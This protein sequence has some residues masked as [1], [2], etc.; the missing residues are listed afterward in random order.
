[1]RN[2][3]YSLQ[4]FSN[5]R[6]FL[7][8]F[9]LSTTI[10]VAQ[11]QTDS[12]KVVSPEQKKEIQEIIKSLQKVLDSIQK[13][14]DAIRKRIV[15]ER[16]YI[17]KWNVNGRLTFLFNQTAFSNWSSGGENAV[18]G[19]L[20]L[21]YD[22]NY[23]DKNW[24]WDNKIIS[25]YGVS[26]IADKGYRKNDDRFEYNSVLAYKRNLKYYYLSFLTNLITQFSNG[27]DYTKDPIIKISSPFSPTYLSF[28]PGVLW[29]K[30]DD[31]RINIAP[32]TSRITFVSKGF[33]GA[34]GVPEGETSYYGVGFNLSGFLKFQLTDNLTME[35]LVAIYSDYSN[36]PQ[37]IDINYQTN[38]YL[39]FNKYLS[40]N[41]TLHIISDSNAS[42]RIQLREVFGLGV[43]YTFHKI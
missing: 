34:Y 33:S 2:K 15:E 25:S 42:S 17:K 12:I 6:S 30:S 10:S 7:F 23:A 21:I 37:N 32:A 8:I 28:G 5:L 1:M 4:L 18:S 41:F 9:L 35:N 16:G 26:Y 20:N 24:K 43:N 31:L 40:T 38:F 13:E 19:A 36:K 22:F 39:N 27:Y 14:E 3:F 11:K 29:R